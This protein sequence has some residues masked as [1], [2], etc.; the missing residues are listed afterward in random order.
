M[1]IFQTLFLTFSVLFF[2]QVDL[3]SQSKNVLFL[4]NSYTAFNNLPLLTANVAESM[5]DSIYQDRNTPGGHTLEGHSTNPTSLA[6]I[7]EGIWDYVVLQEQSQR[8]SFPIGQ[9]EQE[10]FPFAETLNE[11]ILTHNSC[12]ETMFYMTWG[13]KNGD[14]GNCPF[15]PPVCT[16][17]GMDSLL[18]LRYRM[19]GEM[20]EAIVSPVG[21]VWNYIRSNYPDIELYNPDESHPS[22]KGSYAAAV[23]HYTSM[24]RKDPT[25]IPYNYNLTE[26]EANQIKEA[27]KMVLF[28]NMQEWYIG[29]YD[30]IA[31][32]ES[33]NVQG[34][35]Y[36]FTS[37]SQNA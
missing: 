19:M 30:L 16:Y 35:E 25:L 24:F 11:H 9:V 20:N 7:E 5:G 37:T 14:G 36:E 29:D 33:E 12:A 15:W 18:N 26:E 6:L 34:L 31:S 2:N 23:T 13:R 28:E 17:D 1:R 3:N 22:Q 8:P 10:V 21:A 32:F 4:G 27:C